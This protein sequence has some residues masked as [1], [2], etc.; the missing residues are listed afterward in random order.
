VQTKF[1]RAWRRNQEHLSEV[2]GSINKYRRIHCRAAN[3]LCSI[4]TSKIQKKSFHLFQDLQFHNTQVLS[5]I[6][7]GTSKI[8][9]CLQIPGKSQLWWVCW[10]Y[11]V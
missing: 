3:H 1:S 8:K 2:W 7:T 10:S 4:Q 6:Q 5:C 9:I 11:D